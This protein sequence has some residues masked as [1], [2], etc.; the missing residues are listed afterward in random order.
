MAVISDK[1]SGRLNLAGES[2]SIMRDL[3]SG[4]ADI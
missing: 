3:R 2:R 4:N 1:W